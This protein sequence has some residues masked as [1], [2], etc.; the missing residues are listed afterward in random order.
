MRMTNG[1]AGIAPEAISAVAQAERA[2]I[3]AGVF[4]RMEEVALKNQMKV[5][6][7]LQENRVEA[8]HFASSTGYGYDDIGRDT[9]D[10]VYAQ[11]LALRR[12]WCARR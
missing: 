10:R 9:L 12:R 7:A 8:R 1:W 4:A 5:M 6:E 3:Q 11:A 2:L